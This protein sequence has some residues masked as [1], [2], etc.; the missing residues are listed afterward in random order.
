MPDILEAWLLT[1]GGV[2]LILVDLMFIPGGIILAAGAGCMLWAVW[3]AH[4][5]AGIWAAAAHLA[6][7]LAISPKLVSFGLR[8][9]ALR[10]EMRPEDGYVA[11]PDLTPWVG[12]EG[13]AASA[14]RPVGIV[15]LSRGGRQEKI[16][17]IA[18]GGQYIDSGTP[19][20]VLRQEGSSLV[21]RRLSRAPADPAVS[22]PTS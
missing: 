7:S 22:I 11:V 8:R 6:V 3:M 12:A 1:L 4:E 18:E 21:V 19:V 16:E 20:C 2:L 10:N 9:G 13:V 17:A 15:H 5:A 14:L